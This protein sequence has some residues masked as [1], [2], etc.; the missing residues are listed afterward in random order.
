MKVLAV[1]DSML[2]RRL[3]ASAVAVIDFECI[4]AKDGQDALRI[5]EE[6]NGEVDLI[7]MDWNMPNMNGYDCL[8]AVRADECYKHIPVLMLTTE[9]GHD[10]VVAAIKAGATAYLS[11][12]FSEQDLQAKILECL[13]MGFD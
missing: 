5:L 3:V 8:V 11:K 2:I 6:N 1:D 7:C 13:G 12:P 10:S 9:V 4:G